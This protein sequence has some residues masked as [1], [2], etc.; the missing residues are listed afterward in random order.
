MVRNA[1]LLGALSSGE[2]RL[3]VKKLLLLQ[4]VCGRS[5]DRKLH[6]YSSCREHDSK[7]ADIVGEPFRA[8][9]ESHM[10]RDDCQ[11]L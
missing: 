5:Q 2:R 1:D 4:L 6:H 10:Q 3:I 9:T 7:Y 8:V 11:A